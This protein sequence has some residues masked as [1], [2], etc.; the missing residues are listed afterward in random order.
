M[1][2][3]SINGKPLD[4][5]GDA[6]LLGEL[7]HLRRDQA[8]DLEDDRPTDAIECLFVDVRR[9]VPR[10]RGASCAVRGWR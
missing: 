1:M 3:L 6:E 4:L 8:E 7:E 9:I 2:D 10:R 5:C